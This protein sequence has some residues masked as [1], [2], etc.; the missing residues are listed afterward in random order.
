MRNLTDR[1]ESAAVCLAGPGTIKDRLI[2]AYGKCLA[3]LTEEDF[4]KELRSDFAELVRALH[5][6]RALPGE[7]IV[8]AS[9]RKLSPEEAR[10]YTTLIVRAY[11]TLA[12]NAS[13]PAAATRMSAPLARLLAADAA[14]PVVRAAAVNPS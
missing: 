10:H 3:D 14:A 6:E 7:S 12:G 11:G 4:P 9:V 2:E 13:A 5:R 1:L 8:R